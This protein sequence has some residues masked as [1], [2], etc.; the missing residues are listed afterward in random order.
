MHREAGRIISVHILWRPAPQNSAAFWETSR[1]DCEYLWNGSRHQQTA[2]STTVYNHSH[3]EEKLGE[4]WSTNNGVYAANVYT[5]RIDFLEVQI[6][7]IRG[8]APSNFYVVQ[9]GQG[10]ITHMTS[11]TKSP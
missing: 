5:P 6:S 4:L 9:N 1:F 7:A 2:L 11:G 8:A 3:V 10:L